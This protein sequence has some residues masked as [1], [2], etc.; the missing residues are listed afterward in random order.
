LFAQLLPRQK[1][2]IRVPEPVWGGIVEI[3]FWPVCDI[4][5]TIREPPSPRVMQVFDQDHQKNAKADTPGAKKN[6]CG[7]PKKS[8]SLIEI[9]RCTFSLCTRYQQDGTLSSKPNLHA[10]Q[11][12][13]LAAN[14]SI[15]D[16]DFGYGL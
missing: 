4:D 8:I 5:K 12:G 7:A 13:A 1:I 11:S 15:T 9:L 16:S 14:T 3:I 6:H 2:L 10:V